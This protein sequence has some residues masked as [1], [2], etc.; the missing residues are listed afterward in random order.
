LVA[1]E[2]LT[3][4]SHGCGRFA[5]GGTLGLEAPSGVGAKTTENG[6]PTADVVQATRDRLLG[7]LG[8]AS[9]SVALLRGP[10]LVY[11]YASDLYRR[12][13]QI[14]GDPVGK[15]FGLTPRQD[16]RARALFERVYTT[17]EPF[18]A[19]EYGLRF[20]E[21]SAEDDGFFNFA[22]VPTRD[23]QGNVDG[24]LVQ[25]FDV[26]ALVLSRK[27]VEE[28]RA[29]LEAS[30]AQLLQVQKLESLGVLAGG[31]AHDFNNLLTAILGGASTASLVL[32]ADSPAQPHLRDTVL[33]VRRAADLTRQLLAYSGKGHFEVRP[34]DLSTVVREIARLLETSVPRSVALRLELS[35]ALPAV[36]ADVV[37]LQQIVMNLVINGAEAIGDRSGTVTVTT[38]A[39]DIDEA[40][41]RGAFAA[42]GLAAGRYVHL[43]V[44]DTGS[45]MDEVTREKIFDPFFTTKFAG[46]GLGLAAVLGIVRAHRGAIQVDSTPGHGTTFELLLP[47]TSQR[48]VTS[49]DSEFPG[50]RGAGQ[51]VLV[52]DDDDAV[53]TTLR[54]LLELFDFEVVEA[55]G[56]RAAA[57][58]AEARPEIR[59]VVLDMTMPEMSGEATFMEL[60]RIRP[61]LPIILSSGYDEVEASRRFVSKGL[62]GFL[63]KPF[64][65]TDLV[66]C[67]AKALDRN[68]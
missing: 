3:M 8:H 25:G 6:T 60:R 5:V 12:L 14:D 53:R 61:D 54:R 34:V 13:A 59:L 49:R 4:S 9:A 65:T 11:E 20:D 19:N 23:A 51:L 24:L 35:R 36:E 1:L 10:E 7:A 43:R 2:R 28:Q 32:P 31:I 27:K 22:I 47:A 46:R 58:V 37:Q 63:Q 55:E 57:R 39:R 64:T 18:Y 17:G 21:K 52:V 38:S 16:A 48:A 30:Q 44:R 66:R 41:A 62:A 42:Q 29:Q 50:Y 68:H 15:A 45:G 40:S 33:A 56:G 67:I 26:T